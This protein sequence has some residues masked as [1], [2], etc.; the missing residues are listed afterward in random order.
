[1]IGFGTN[2]VQ[3]INATNGVIR[4]LGAGFFLSQY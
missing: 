3:I 4:S 2:T 1:M